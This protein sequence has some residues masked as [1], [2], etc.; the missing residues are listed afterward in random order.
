MSRTIAGE[1]GSG[2]EYWSRRCFGRHGLS[3][4]KVSKQITTRKE[5]QRD[6]RMGR[7]A[8]NDSEKFESRFPGE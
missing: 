6:K 3:P 4:G 5:R 8:L 2:H 1:K 7:I